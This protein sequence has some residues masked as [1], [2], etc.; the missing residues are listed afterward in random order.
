MKAVAT[1][2]AV[3]PGAELLADRETRDAL[4][5]QSAVLRTL[6]ARTG[7]AF[8][9]NLL[10]ST[11]AEAAEHPEGSMYGESYGY[12]RSP[13]GQHLRSPGWAVARFDL[14]A[15]FDPYRN[16]SWIAP[17]PLLMIAGTAADTPE[18]SDNGVAMAGDNAE[19]FDIEGATHIDLYFRDEYVSQAVDKLVDFYTTNL[20]G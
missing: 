19:L 12:Y 20:N 14:V 1:I 3:D 11:P 13:A 16:N 5:D 8:A 2:S 15:Q 6:E 9:M 17:R 10:P 18:F 4:L 7:G